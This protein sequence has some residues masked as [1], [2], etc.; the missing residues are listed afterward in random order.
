MTADPFHPADAVLSLKPIVR[1]CGGELYGGGRRAN[2]PAPG[3]SRHDRSVSLWLQ[4]G[5][6]VVHSFGSADWREVLDDLRARGL[7][8]ARCAPRGGGNTDHPRRAEPDDRVRLETAQR[9]WSEARP[10]AGSL[11]ER[12]LR[13]RRIGWTPA[14]DALRHHPRV[15]TAIY[16][17][18]GRR[19]PALLAGVRDPLGTLTAVEITYLDSSGRRSE[20]LRVPRKTIGLVRPGSA[21][22]LEVAGSELLVGEGVFTTLSA[23]GRFGLPGWALLSIRNLK[24]WRAPP[25][26]ARVLIAADRGRP[27]EA[28]AAWLQSQLEAQGVR[29]RVAL[30]PAPFGDWNEVDAAE[31]EGGKGGR[32]RARRWVG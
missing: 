30:P 8:D 9:L 17:D 32:S 14:A 26:V 13:L 18:R 22:R 29:T 6:V 12:H 31:P 2:I 7:V 28:A 16:A 5:R 19:L 11:S 3:H 23:E 1:A 15:P 25:G 24:S 27:G 20:R 4:N 10:L 21:V